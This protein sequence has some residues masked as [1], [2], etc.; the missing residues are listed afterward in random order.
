MTNIPLILLDFVLLL[1]ITILR[2][3]I[4]YFFGSRYNIKRL[5]C[6]DV[7]MHSENLK[8]NQN[9]VATIEE[10]IRVN[11]KNTMDDMLHVQKNK[12]KS[13]I[14]PHF[15]IHTHP[16]SIPA[17]AP[18]SV[19]ASVPQ[20][21]EMTEDL[22]KILKNE[23]EKQQMHSVFESKS[24]KINK[25]D[26]QN[27]LL[28]LTDDMKIQEIKTEKDDEFEFDDYGESNDSETVKRDSI[29]HS[30]FKN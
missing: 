15:H 2:L 12:R 30:I 17:P 25:Y 1:P 24:S 9:N 16:T 4:I 20:P 21:K 22:K 8:F 13:N 23:F 28:E 6:L 18:V 14:I 26:E 19:P 10:D 3:T 7:M 29:S 11:I 27:G 5:S